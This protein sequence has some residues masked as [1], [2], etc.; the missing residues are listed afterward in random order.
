MIW[1]NRNLSDEELSF[2]YNHAKISIGQLSSYERVNRTIPHKAY[3]AGFFGLPYVSA[4][5]KSLEELFKI[6]DDY[7]P[8]NFPINPVLD[9]A[10]LAVSTS[11]A[12]S[13]DPLSKLN[14]I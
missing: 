10:T 1:I 12:N 13:S 14:D 6:N 9:P 5:S 8:I 11:F 2:C 4:P 7:F 3:E